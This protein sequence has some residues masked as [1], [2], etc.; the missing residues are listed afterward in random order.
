MQPIVE[1]VLRSHLVI[2]TAASRPVTLTQQ[3]LVTLVRDVAASVFP[4]V[5]PARNAG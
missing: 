5:A 4:D 1:P 3:A 2:A